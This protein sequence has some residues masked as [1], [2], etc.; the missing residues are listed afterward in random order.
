MHYCQQ[1]EEPVLMQPEEN[2]AVCPDCRS[3]APARRLPLFVVTGAS[4]SGK[5]TVFPHL[6]AALGEC[7]VFD[8]D[9]LI[10]SFH[11][12]GAF[13]ELDWPAFRDA[14]LSVAHG[15]AQGG[16]HTVLLGP[17]MPDQLAGLPARRWIGDIHFAVLDC[18]DDE[19]RARME[20]RP[21]WR[22]RAID[23]HLR[24]AA[25]LRKTIP[26][27]VQTAG[28]PVDTARTLADWVR[29]RLA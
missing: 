4:G 9:W 28:S 23:Q 7:A 15:V 1:C 25:H 29:V 12:V 16:R 27:V 6:A 8:V 26:T 13:E 2:L 20:N 11:G 18:P 10:D 5:T 3:S 14:W 21:R 24:F 17:F 22:E 19:R